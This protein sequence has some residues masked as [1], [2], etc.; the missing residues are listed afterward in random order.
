MLN[1][2][3]EVL[4]PW[5]AEEVIEEEDEEREEEVKASTSYLSPNDLPFSPRPAPDASA[6]V[7]SA[8]S[9]YHTLHIRPAS[10]TPNLQA[11]FARNP[12]PSDSP[13][14]RRSPQLAHR[15]TPPRSISSSS[16]LALGTSDTIHRRF[17]ANPRTGCPALEYIKLPW[18]HD[19]A[20]L[21]QQF[22]GIFTFLDRIRSQGGN[23]LVHCQCGVSRSA[24]A[25]I[26]YVMANSTDHKGMHD[27]YAFVKEKSEWISPNIGLVYQLVEWEKKLRGGSE[28]RSAEEME[29]D[30]GVSDPSTSPT[31]SSSSFESRLATPATQQAALQPVLATS[32]SADGNLLSPSL[33]ETLVISPQLS[34]SHK[35][36]EQILPS[37][38]Q[39]TT[40]SPF[41][42]SR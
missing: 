30:E 10:S 42:Y 3:K 40:S 27:S 28:K 24:S 41:S 34:S 32:P 19:Q 23:V 38:S 33:A 37:F 5:T 31:N 8:P 17:P 20:D 11:A 9:A 2:A 29:V 35:L 13:P 16:S 15:N 21:C 18:N 4:C 25:V 36:A 12:S 14:R 7:E 39:R 6:A 22:V 26:G 1:V